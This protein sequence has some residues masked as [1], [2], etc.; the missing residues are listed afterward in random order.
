MIVSLCNKS[1]NLRK[2]LTLYQKQSFVN[3]SSLLLNLRKSVR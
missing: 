3:T 2:Y 1:L